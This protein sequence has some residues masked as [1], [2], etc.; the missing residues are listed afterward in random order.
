V[1]KLTKMLMMWSKKT[2]VVGDDDTVK[3]SGEP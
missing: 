3:F 1:R 2:M